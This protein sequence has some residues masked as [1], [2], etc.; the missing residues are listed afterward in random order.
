[1][2]DNVAGMA[3]AD[4]AE[5]V[6]WSLVDWLGGLRSRDA[7]VLRVRK[8]DCGVPSER[9]AGDAAHSEEQANRIRVD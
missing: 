6:D 7:N 3:R 9:A 2:T 1:V 8:R 4:S 5:P